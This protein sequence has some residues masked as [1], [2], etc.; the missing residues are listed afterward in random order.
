MAESR[1]RQTYESGERV[2][3][4][5]GEGV[6]ISSRVLE[7]PEGQMVCK[8]KHDIYTDHEGDTFEVNVEH[9]RHI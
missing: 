3:S 7:R 8:V 5:L 6:I 1:C 9:L 4:P 2:L